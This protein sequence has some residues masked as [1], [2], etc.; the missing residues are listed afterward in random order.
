M[1]MSPWRPLR[2]FTVLVLLIAAMVSPDLSSQGRRGRGTV[3]VDGREAVDGEV[4]VRFRDS[5]ATFEQARAA[6]DVEADEVE[7]LGLRGTRRVRA[8]RLST[9]ELLVRLRANPDVEFVEPNYIIRLEAAPNDPSF[10]NL[11]GLLNWGQNYGGVGLAGADIDAALAWD[12]AEHISPEGMTGEATAGIVSLSGGALFA[13]VVSVI[14]LVI[15]TVSF[16]R[17]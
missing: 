4:L 10:N 6:D 8:R 2:H 7:P 15:E 5:A 1:T 9:S 13:N 16:Q 3:F 12:I 14:L 11:W 17:R